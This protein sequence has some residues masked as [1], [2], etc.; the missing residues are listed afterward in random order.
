VTQSIFT[1]F[2]K[3]NCALQN[4]RKSRCSMLQHAKICWVLPSNCRLKHDKTGID[5]CLNTLHY[6][7]NSGFLRQLEFHRRQMTQ[8]RSNLIRLNLLRSHR[9]YFTLTVEP[10]ERWENL[11]VRLAQSQSQCSPETSSSLSCSSKESSSLATSLAL[12][13]AANVL[14]EA[15]FVALGASIAATNLQHSSCFLF[16]QQSAAR[17]GSGTVFTEDHC[18]ISSF[19]VKGYY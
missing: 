15:S 1:S 12:V 6:F 10:A 19:P 9:L 2:F 18:S 17:A 3:A 7:S 16:S 13:S 8:I 11:G 14:R 4:A 5:S